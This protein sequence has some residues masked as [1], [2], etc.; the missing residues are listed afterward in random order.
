MSSP[1]PEA[2]RRPGRRRA[3]AGTAALVALARTASAQRAPAPDSRLIVAF[4]PGGSIDVPAAALARLAGPALGESIALTHLAGGSGR[5]AL[6]ALRTAP[7]DG[8]TLLLATS[9]MLTLGPA[10]RASEWPDP[11]RELAPVA[12]VATLGFAANVRADV[13]ATDLASF[14]AWARNQAAQGRAVH[15]GSHGPGTVSH[16]CGA[17]VDRT[18]RL[19]LVHLP[20][21][22][23]PPARAALE[24]GHVQLV[25]DTVAD[26]IAPVRERRATVIA[27]T[28]TDR[29]SAL[30]DAATL[31]EQRVP[32]GAVDAWLAVVAPP[33]VPAARL[34]RLSAALQAAV[35]SAD[36]KAT[37]REQGL[38]SAAGGPQAVT[39][40]ITADLA[41]WTRSIRAIGFDQAN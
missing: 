21:R 37:M 14:V 22:G 2:C 11:Q 17:L 31:V 40:A 33:G 9:A 16:F 10:L 5:V 4:P 34:E 35:G 3:L 12:M 8:H 6:D 15:Y 7:P 27:T 38:S 26:S 41:R 29:S 39:A 23:G 30:P 36:M 28:G 1:R 19:G 20:F 25:F 18:F 32:N 24:A 13:P